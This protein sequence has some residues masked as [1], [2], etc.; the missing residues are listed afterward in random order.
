[1]CPRRDHCLLPTVMLYFLPGWLDESLRIPKPF[2]KWA[3][4]D[5]T[6]W[7]IA[8]NNIAPAP[9]REFAD[10]FTPTVQHGNLIPDHFITAHAVRHDTRKSTTRGL[11]N[12]KT[13]LFNGGPCAHL[14]PLRT[15]NLRP[16]G[17]G[18]ELPCPLTCS[19]KISRST[20]QSGL[21]SQPDRAGYWRLS[22]TDYLSASHGQ[23]TAKS[24]GW[25]CPGA[26]MICQLQIVLHCKNRQSRKA[27]ARSATACSEARGCAVCSNELTLPRILSYTIDRL[28]M[29]IVLRYFIYDARC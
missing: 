5:V 16:L 27:D 26:V 23:Q 28:S 2:P 11:Q 20:V 29:K 9:T 22:T 4:D 18:F 3:G 8:R 1:M 19:R 25:N 6:T 12:V 21:R 15:S 13:H 24:G 14:P 17:K 7:R 10:D